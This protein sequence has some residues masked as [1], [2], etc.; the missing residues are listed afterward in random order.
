MTD[1]SLHQSTAKSNPPICACGCGTPLSPSKHRQRLSD[2]TIIQ[3]GEFF[4]F[5]RN[6]QYRGRQSNMWEYLLS[7]SRIEGTCIVW[8]GHK[9]PDAYPLLM[10]RGK[11]RTV[12]VISWMLQHGEAPD[13][14]VIMHRCDN[15]PCFNPDHLQ[16]GT[17]TENIHDAIAKGRLVFGEHHGNSKLTADAVR[18]IRVKCDMGYSRKEISEQFGI[19]PNHIT[20]I[21]TRREWKSVI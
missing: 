6:H 7:R 15:P 5:A 11:R 12:H 21:F 13:G 16:A 18:E 20:R 19:T 4:R 1:R 14:L 9:N 17:T 3:K 10:F 8:T 2:G